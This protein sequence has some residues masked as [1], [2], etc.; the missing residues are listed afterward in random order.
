MQENHE[1]KAWAV[2]GQM[3]EALSGGH[4]HSGRRRCWRR[5]PATC[6]SH[7]GEGSNWQEETDVLC[8]DKKVDGLKLCIQNSDAWNRQKSQYSKTISSKAVQTGWHSSRGHSW[9]SYILLYSCLAD[10][11]LLLPFSTTLHRINTLETLET[12]ISQK[13]ENTNKIWLQAHRQ[14]VVLLH[15]EHLRGRCSG[16]E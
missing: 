13:C 7:A 15:V 5:L 6:C 10:S 3:Q 14:C 8:R 16:T 4:S 1:P 9:W 11:S 2:T 12:M